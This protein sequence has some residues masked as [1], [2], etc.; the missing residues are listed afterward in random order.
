MWIFKRRVEEPEPL[1]RDE[2][3]RFVEGRTRYYFKMS[4]PEFRAALEA[5]K[6]DEN[7]AATDIALLLGE[8][9]R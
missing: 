2:F 7:L 4:V 8:A 9:A 6:L 5:G 1:S 3:E